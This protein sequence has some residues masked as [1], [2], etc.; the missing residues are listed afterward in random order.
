MLS[1]GV[2]RKLAMAL[3]GEDP[4]RLGP[5]EVTHDHG[6]A[7]QPGKSANGPGLKASKA[8][9]PL[10][11]QRHMYKSAD[12]VVKS[13]M[14]QQLLEGDQWGIGSEDRRSSDCLL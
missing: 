6:T 13:S 8:Q 1:L 7:L 14:H 5:P 12:Q 3:A 11:H 9:N 4:L 2:E 10:G